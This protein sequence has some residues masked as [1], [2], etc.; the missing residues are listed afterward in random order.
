MNQVIGSKTFLTLKV[1]S[2]ILGEIAIIKSG[3]FPEKFQ[4]FVNFDRNFQRE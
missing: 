2:N 1:C 3:K 4:K